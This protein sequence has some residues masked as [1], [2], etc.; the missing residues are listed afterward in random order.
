MNR[1]RTVHPWTSSKS[2]E[3]ETAATTPDEHNSTP[4][5]TRLD[6]ESYKFIAAIALARRQQDLSGGSPAGVIR[7]ALKAYI[8]DRLDDPELERRIATSQERYAW[9]VESL[10]TRANGSTPPPA[11]QVLPIPIRTRKERPVTVRVDDGTLQ[12]LEGLALIDETGL[13][14]QIRMAVA[15]YVNAQRDDNQ[16]MQQVQLITEASEALANVGF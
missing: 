16:V 12:L 10:R 4:V 7:L 6:Q 11:A 5:S 15:R 2:D 9:I 14:D 13:A 3:Q 1:A 8:D